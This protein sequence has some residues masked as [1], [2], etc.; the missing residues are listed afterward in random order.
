MWT[1]LG[2]RNHYQEFCL[3]R[4]RVAM[5]R[6]HCRLPVD[7]PAATAITEAGVRPSSRG[8]HVEFATVGLSSRLSMA[9]P[10]LISDYSECSEQPYNAS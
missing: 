8:A 10:S 2:Y 5:V 7:L 6:D 9:A 1:D 4:L 3:K